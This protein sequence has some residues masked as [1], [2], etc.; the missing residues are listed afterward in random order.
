MTILME[1]VLITEFHSKEN[2]VQ[3]FKILMRTLKENLSLVY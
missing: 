2:L 1:Y 3:T